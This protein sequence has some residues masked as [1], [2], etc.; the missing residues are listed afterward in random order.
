MLSFQNITQTQ[1]LFTQNVLMLNM[2]AS[3]YSETAAFS[4]RS[5]MAHASVSV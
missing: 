5:V 3:N 1:M 4:Y 2:E